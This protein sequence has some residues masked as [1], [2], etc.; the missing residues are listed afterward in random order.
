[1]SEAPR[2]LDRL[3]ENFTKD[4]PYTAFSRRRLVYLNPFCERADLYNQ[5]ASHYYL[6]SSF[7]AFHLY[8]HVFGLASGIFREL[9]ASS[10]A[11]E[12]VIWYPDGEAMF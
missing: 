2:L 10:Q 6:D 1:M 12:A 11:Q 3:E 8:P 7:A 5:A 9:S 4:Q